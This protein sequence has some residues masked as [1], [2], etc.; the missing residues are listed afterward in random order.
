MEFNMGGRDLQLSPNINDP[1]SALSSAH[2]S[3]AHGSALGL[4]GTT[5]TLFT[6]ATTFAS[7]RAA[8]RRLRRSLQSWPRRNG[9]IETRSPGHVA[10][11]S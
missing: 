5:T 6:S 10:S 1:L 9:D 2:T 3:A 8:S 7:F 4:S 11:R